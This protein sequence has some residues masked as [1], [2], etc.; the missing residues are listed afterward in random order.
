[1]NSMSYYALKKVLLTNKLN[2]DSYRNYLD[3]LSISGLKTEPIPINTKVILIGDY[4]T[5]DTLYNIDEDFKALFKVRVDMAETLDVTEDSGIFIREFIKSRFYKYNLTEVSDDA[6]KE[7]VRYLCR[8]TDNKDKMKI[9]IENIDN[10]L[11]LLREEVKDRGIEYIDKTDIINIAYEKES[12][13]DELLEMYKNK[14]ILLSL[15]G[16]KIGIING[17]AVIDSGYYRFGKPIRITCIPNKGIGKIIDI[18]KESNMS[19]A[20]HEK[21]INI[22]EGI[23][24]KL[25]ESYGRL[26]VN[27]RVSFEQTYGIIDGDSASVAEMLCILSSLA[28][29]PIKQNIAVTGSLN[30]FGE[31][32]AIGGL[33]EKVEGF[34]KICK[35]LNKAK[36]I[37]VLIP[38]SNVNELIL[39]PELEEAIT[40]GELVIYTMDTLEDAIKVMIQEDLEEFYNNIRYEIEKYKL[41]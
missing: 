20:I 36:N 39:L 13:E 21:S 3:L 19:G 41:N 17:L 31:V 4:E 12:I 25:F 40:R 1:M 9:K 37:G 15:D 32:Q 34:Y 35:Y 11:L 5:Y 6:I 30:L 24:S 7:V 16:E 28:K 10:L 22:L 2:L 29:K 23:L 26:P 38:N 18:Q 33:K 8:E 27:F 14:K